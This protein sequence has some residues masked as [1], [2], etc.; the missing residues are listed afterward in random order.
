MPR[1]LHVDLAD[2]AWSIGGGPARDSYL[3]IDKLLEVA[4]RSRAEAVH[5]GYG[6]LS[7]NP[8]FAEACAAAGLIFV[9]PPA[10]AMRS[11]GSKALA[12]TLMQRAGVAIPPGYHGDAMD[13]ATLAAAAEHIGFPLL[14]KA[15]SG[16]GGRGMR[17]VQEAERT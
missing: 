8:A 7:E 6:F 12:K 4:R 10:S 15:S 13:L 1:A 2:E 17:L 3:A 5:P 14:V 11:M 16:G 9:G